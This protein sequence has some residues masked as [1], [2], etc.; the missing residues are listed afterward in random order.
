MGAF[1]LENKNPEISVGRKVS[2]PI[3]KKLFHSLAV[4]LG[5]VR[6][7]LPNG[8]PRWLRGGN[9]FRRV[10]KKKRLKFHLVLMRRKTLM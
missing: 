6:C 9:N 10:G 1:H 7:S 5:T 8:T 3:G 2:F 4:N